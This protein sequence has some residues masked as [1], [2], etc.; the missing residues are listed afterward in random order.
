MLHRPERERFSG[1]SL[2]VT[3]FDAAYNSKFAPNSKFQTMWMFFGLRKNVKDND[4]FGVVCMKVADYYRFWSGK[5]VSLM[6]DQHQ[7]Q[8]HISSV[9]CPAWFQIIPI[10]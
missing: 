4:I 9:P 8:P 5:M 1:L 3:G 2:A 10:F 6:T 7:V